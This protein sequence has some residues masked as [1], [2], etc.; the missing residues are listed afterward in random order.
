MQPNPSLGI[1]TTRGLSRDGIVPGITNI[2][3]IWSDVIRPPAPVPSP[4]V[5][6]VK[7]W[8]VLLAQSEEE[9]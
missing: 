9:G 2:E 7:L 6:S 8:Q 5:T 3:N 4:A 1:Y